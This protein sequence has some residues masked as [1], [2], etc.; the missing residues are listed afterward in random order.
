[1][2]ELSPTIR[3]IKHMHLDHG[4]PATVIARRFGMSLRIVRD[5]CRDAREKETDSE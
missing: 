5:I 2:S 3:L 1:V 4:I